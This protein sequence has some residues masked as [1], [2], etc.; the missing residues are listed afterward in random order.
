[1]VKNSIK[2]LQE[3]DCNCNDC[4]NMVRDFKRFNESLELHRKWQLDYFNTIKKKLIDRAEWHKARGDQGTCNQLISEAMSMNF[5]FNR[6][7]ALINYGKCCKFNKDVSFIPGV[8][9]LDTQ[10]C[11]IHRKDS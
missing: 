1:M 4:K 10:Q 5:Q 8:L 7:E 6:N 11:F 9:Q 2:L 3:L